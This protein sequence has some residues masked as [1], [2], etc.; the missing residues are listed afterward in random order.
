MASFTSPRYIENSNVKKT[1]KKKIL[2]TEPCRIKK[3][4]VKK[5]NLAT[6]S[7]SFSLCIFAVVYLTKSPM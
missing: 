1:I 7:F 2:S 6:Y 4:N 3:Q 5:D